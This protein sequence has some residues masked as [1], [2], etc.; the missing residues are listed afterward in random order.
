MIVM[1]TALAG[2]QTTPGILYVM[3]NSTSFSINGTTGDSPHIRLTVVNSED[4]TVSG[5]SVVIWGPDHRTA[6]AGTTDD[7]GEFT[8]RLENISLPAGKSEGYMAVKVM[9]EG[10]LD[11]NEQYLIK[12]RST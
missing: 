11:L 3:S 4:E 5:A 2:I 10:Y 9:Q 12:V 7:L 6:T 8:F 1:M